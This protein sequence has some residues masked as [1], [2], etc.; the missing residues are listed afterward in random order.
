MT[1]NLLDTA[2]VLVVMAAL[3]A[4]VNHRFLALP[5]T[6][7]LVVSA[8][9]A[10]IAVLALD[11]L[12]P[13]LGLGETV[14]Q[15]VASIDF[16]ETLMRGML[17]F[18]LFAGALHVNLDDL[19]EAKTPVLVLASVGVLL[20]T[21]IVGLGAYGLFRLAQVPVPLT[22]CLV[23]G[24][25]ISPTDPVAVLGILK[26]AGAPRML[27]V[28]VAGE[29]LFNDGV[30]VIVFT[31]L[32]GIAAGPSG[33]A[34]GTEA[35]GFEPGHVLVIFGRE[36]IGG[37]LLGL[38]LGLIAYGAMRSLEEP[39]LEILFSM[40]LVMTISFVAAKLHTSAPLGCV[41]AGLFIGNHGRRLAMDAESRQALDLVW[42]FVDEALNAVLFLLVGLEVL[43]VSLVG[44]HVV[45]A[46]LFIPLALAARF[47]SV[48]APVAVMRWRREFPPGAI[49]VLTW[50]GL[51]GGISVALALSLPP[52]PGRSAVLT[53]TYAVVIFSIIVQGLSMRRVVRSVSRPAADGG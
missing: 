47:V 17:G 37:V 21:F 26:S 6:I 22:W 49:R 10:S 33:A 8:L 23:F 38:A 1:A 2:T 46:L 39:N 34:H 44:R 3:F 25:L 4:Y 53:A 20:S 41:V 5:F 45:A 51:K 24:A 36:V 16:P 18:L 7:G 43:A 29:S 9:T 30:G 42:S 52:F 28:K 27:E 35:A 13:S 40:A 48:G 19:F 11:A 12:V 31:V 15:R 50:G 14:R 32:L